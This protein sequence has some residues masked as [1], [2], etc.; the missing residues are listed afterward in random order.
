MRLDH[1]FSKNNLRPIVLLSCLLG[2]ATL[3]AAYADAISDAF[4]ALQSNP[5]DATLNLR[6]AAAAEKGGK[7]KWALP[8]YERA[9]MADPRN[10]EARAGI[11][12]VTRKIRED[13]AKQ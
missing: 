13:A 6:Y 3:H 5:A 4:Q 11:D 1:F 10:P 2:L 12:R 8:A 9:L 7:L